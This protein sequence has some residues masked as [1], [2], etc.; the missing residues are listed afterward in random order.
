MDIPTSNWEWLETI[1]RYEVW[2]RPIAGTYVYQVTKDSAD[3]PTV[4]AGYANKN[5]LLRMKGLI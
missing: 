1:G 2:R 3:P 5:A 4:Y